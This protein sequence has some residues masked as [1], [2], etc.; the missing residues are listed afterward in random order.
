MAKTTETSAAKA[1]KKALLAN[2]K[3]MDEFSD[4]QGELVEQKMK[5][6]ED[7]TELFETA[8]KNN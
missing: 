6:D 8:Q 2:T 7:F 3:W 1:A 4:V 5:K